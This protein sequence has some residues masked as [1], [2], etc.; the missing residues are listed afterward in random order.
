MEASGVVA[1]E[2][3]VMDVAGTVEATEVAVAEQDLQRVSMEV[4]EA[5]AAT[6]AAAT[7]EAEEA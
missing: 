5:V 3:A 4:A 6:V 7:V 1:T 2:A